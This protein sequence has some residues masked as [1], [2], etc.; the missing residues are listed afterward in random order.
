MESM[1]SM[2][3]RRIDDTLNGTSRNMTEYRD[4]LRKL[5][6]NE[7]KKAL[8]TEKQDAINELIEEQRKALREIIDEHKQVIR[9]VVE[10]QKKVIH[11]RAEELRQSIIKMGI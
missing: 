8:E 1:E 4:S 10:E 7:V 2:V 3:G 11:L 5:I 9:E 6:E